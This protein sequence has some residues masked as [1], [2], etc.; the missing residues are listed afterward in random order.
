MT[1][2]MAPSFSSSMEAMLLNPLTVM[3][4]SSGMGRFPGRANPIVPHLC[5]NRQATRSRAIGLPA[6][7]PL[8]EP[9]VRRRQ[10]HAG[11]AGLGQLLDGE[12]ADLAELVV[13]HRQPARV[14]LAGEQQ[15]EGV[16][17]AL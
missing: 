10:G 11:V 1:T 5:T 4:S 17:L 13:G 14:H 12:P 8:A 6:L 3:L 15:Q 9:E 16:P 2:L 7:G